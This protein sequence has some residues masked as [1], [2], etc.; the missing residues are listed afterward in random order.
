M[1]A[2]AMGP[3][4]L[5][6]GLRIRRGGAHDDPLGAIFEL[7]MWETVTIFAVILPPEREQA[8]RVVAHEEIALHAYFHWERRGRP[9]G[10]AEVD[11]HWAIDNLRGA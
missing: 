3:V 8:S 5:G 9:F 7:V 11:W 4:H 10:S 1:G 2:F 6:P